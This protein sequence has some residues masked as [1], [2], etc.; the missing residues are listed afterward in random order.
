MAGAREAEG[1][2]QKEVVA[3]TSWPEA[4]TSS[5]RGAQKSSLRH[6]KLQII[7]KYQS[8]VWE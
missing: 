8:L 1:A 2:R 5:L 7:W 6:W 4:H 3:V